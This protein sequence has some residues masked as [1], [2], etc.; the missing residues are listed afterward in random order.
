MKFFSAWIIIKS[1]R[2]QRIIYPKA[3]TAT[4]RSQQEILLFHVCVFQYQVQLQWMNEW[5]T[6]QMWGGGS[7]QPVDAV[8]AYNLPAWLCSNGNS[9]R[10][11]SNVNFNRTRAIKLVFC[12]I[13]TS[14]EC[15][16][17]DHPDQSMCLWSAC[18]LLWSELL[19]A[20]SF[21]HD[22]SQSSHLL[23]LCLIDVTSC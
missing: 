10:I 4:A 16:S 1:P 5:R 22:P 7:V 6:I 17:R 21:D 14:V 15:L 12:S 18:A 8:L 9:D 23:P 13:R 3:A 11:V 20:R 2:I 19:N